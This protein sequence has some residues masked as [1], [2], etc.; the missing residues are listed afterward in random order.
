MKTILLVEDNQLLAEN[1]KALLEE[2]TYNVYHTVSAQD[3]INYAEKNSVDIILCDI[4]LPDKDGYDILKEL[5][6]KPNYVLPPFV[7][8]TAKSQRQDRRRGMELGADD[9]LTKPFTQEELLRMVKTQLTKREHLLGDK[10]SGGKKELFDSKQID[11]ESNKKLSY[12][13]YIF[14]NEKSNPGFFAI[15]KIVYIKSMQDYT[16]IFLTNSQKL[17]VRKTLTNWENQLPGEYF[18]RIHRQTIINLQFVEK[19]ERYK[20]YTYKVYLKNISEPF[21]ISQR[22]SRKIKQ[23]QGTNA[24][25]GQ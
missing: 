15:K 24:F 23:M 7:F 5:N 3:C 19:V 12:D 10:S 25:G 17:V 18:V 2:E 11:P 9:Y 21:T 8:L 22:Y 1:I 20:N 4:M 13:S 6:S 16:Q 14:L